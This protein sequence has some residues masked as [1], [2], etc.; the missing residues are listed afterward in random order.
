[1]TVVLVVAVVMIVVVMVLV[2]VMLVA[3][4]VIVVIVMVVVVVILVALCVTWA[5]KDWV[6]EASLSGRLSYKKVSE[7]KNPSDILTKHIQNT[8]LARHL[9]MLK[10]ELRDG[11]PK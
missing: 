2:V 3:D 1:M 8:L 5:R 10:A 9:S 11:S 4:I 6:P 7:T